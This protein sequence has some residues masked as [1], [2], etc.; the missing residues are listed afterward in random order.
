MADEV[1]RE[2]I[3]ADD[4]PTVGDKIE[5]E[6]YS[7]SAYRAI[8]R[9]RVRAAEYGIE[10]P[11]L[12]YPLTPRRAG[13]AKLKIMTILAGL[14]IVASVGLLGWWLVVGMG[15]V[16]AAIGKGAEIVDAAQSIPVLDLLGAVGGGL[17]IAMA[18]GL[19][20]LAALP[21]IMMVVYLVI[22]LRLMAMNLSTEEMAAGY[23]LSHV[24][25]TTIIFA[26]LSLLI[27]VLCLF[28]AVPF[29]VVLLCNAAFTIALFVVLQKERNAAKI[30]FKQLPAEQQATFQAHNDALRTA[31]SRRGIRRYNQRLDYSNM[32]KWAVLFRLIEG[33]LDA[34]IVYDNMKVSP[35]R[36][37]SLG[38]MRRAWRDLLI[39]GVVAALFVTAMLVTTGF[40]QIVFIVTGGIWIAF[41]LL[42]IVPQV[43]NYAIKQLILN[44]HPLGWVT[45]VVTILLVAGVI[46]GVAFVATM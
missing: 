11:Y 2:V 6:S 32:G 37:Q 5:K 19:L 4:K 18:V 7:A 24:K 29:G 12:K 16:F 42:V 41:E 9:V 3:Q 34:R 10:V 28:F 26:I 27:G 8:H 39:F 35:F 46:G 17:V 15:P 21:C 1:T 40:L 31:L 13:N 43:L 45:L 38:L 44:K 36:S 22:L 20:L 14:L 23:Y 25:N 30:D 33:F